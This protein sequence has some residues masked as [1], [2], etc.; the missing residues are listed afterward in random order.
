MTKKQ[1]RQKTRRLI[2]DASDLMRE[3][4]EKALICGAINF[5]NYDD[6]YELPRIILMAL[7]KEA[8][9]QFKPIR[10]P[11]KQQKE[12]NNIYAMI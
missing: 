1:A 5:D 8:T 3:K 11:K 9:F 12:A 10:D 6:D 2:R 7:L 4:L